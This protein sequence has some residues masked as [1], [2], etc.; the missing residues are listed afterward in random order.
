MRCGGVPG[1]LRLCE[2]RQGAAEN[3]AARHPKENPAGIS[4]SDGVLA[5]LVFSEG[6]TE[7]LQW[8]ALKGWGRRGNASGASRVPRRY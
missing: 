1:P 2:R 3:L 7:S 5:L 6:G 4:H 8:G